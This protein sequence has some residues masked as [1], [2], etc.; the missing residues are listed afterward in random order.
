VFTNLLGARVLGATD[1][2]PYNAG[3]AA[4][5]NDPARAGRSLA[6]GEFDH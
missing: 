2:N 1:G 3:A 5:L 4:D 6:G